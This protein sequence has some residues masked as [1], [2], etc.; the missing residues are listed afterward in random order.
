LYLSTEKPAPCCRQIQASDIETF[1]VS[2]RAWDLLS[3][4]GLGAADIAHDLLGFL[5]M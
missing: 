3:K 2:G 1:G 4:N 5:W